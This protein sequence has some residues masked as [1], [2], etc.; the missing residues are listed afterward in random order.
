MQKRSPFVLLTRQAASILLVLSISLVI[1]GTFGIIKSSRGGSDVVIDGSITGFL[2]ETAGAQEY[3]SPTLTP[4]PP[5]IAA[6]AVQDEPAANPEGV[7][8]QNGENE[9]ANPASPESAVT[10]PP[11]TVAPLLSAADTL[12][13]RPEDF[14]FSGG[15]KPVGLRINNVGIGA[16]VVDMGLTED[17]R[18]EAPPAEQIG[19]YEHGPIPGA[20]GSSVLAAHVD[21]GGQPGAFFELRHVVPGDVIEIDYEDGSTQ[22]FEIV[23][24]RQYAKDIVPKKQIFDRSGDPRLVLVT[25][26]G[27]FDNSIGHYEDNFVA[28]ARPIAA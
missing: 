24:S 19:W 25:C 16:S 17:R 6:P 14:T 9:P 27:A 26:G 11:T 28:F 4:A 7:A 3:A 23:A 8:A 10:P 20:E 21:W 22:L 18:L 2:G 1:L 13:A 12:S 5:T 15:P